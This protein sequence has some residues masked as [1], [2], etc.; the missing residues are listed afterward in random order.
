[1]VDQDMH[2]LIGAVEALTT[3]VQALRTD[4]DGLRH[5]VR[6]NNAALRSDLAVALSR[7]ASLG[8]SRKKKLTGSPGLYR[9]SQ[10]E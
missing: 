8:E 2:S 3:E 1:M 5:E 10:P 9:F 4:M 6:H 7:Q